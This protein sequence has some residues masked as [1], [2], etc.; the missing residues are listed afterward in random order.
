MQVK[1]NK[2]ELCR[3]NM[4]INKLAFSFV[5]KQRVSFENG[6]CESSLQRVVSGE[7]RWRKIYKIERPESILPVKSTDEKTHSIF[8]GKRM[9]PRKA[10]PVVLVR[11]NHR[12]R[13]GAR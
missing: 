12:E 2:V 5:S 3:E 1:N 11:H 7:K 13:S 4:S 6:S 8:Y 10:C 9:R